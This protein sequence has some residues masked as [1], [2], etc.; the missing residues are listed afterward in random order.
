MEALPVWLI[1]RPVVGPDETLQFVLQ[2]D[3]T[4]LRVLFRTPLVWRPV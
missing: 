3:Q 1:A 4:P 2:T